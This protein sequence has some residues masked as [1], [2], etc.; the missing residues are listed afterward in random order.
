MPDNS[1]TISELREQ[2][3]TLKAKIAELEADRLQ[4]RKICVGPRG[5]A[6]I[7]PGAGLIK[8]PLEGF[9]TL[10]PRQIPTIALPSGYT[11]L[12]VEQVKE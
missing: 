2:I 8:L 1:N 7:V 3:E 9:A 4:V 12:E 6:V 10:D 11:L 5:L